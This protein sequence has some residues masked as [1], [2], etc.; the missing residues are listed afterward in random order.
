[1]RFCLLLLFLAVVTAEPIRVMFL[2]GVHGREYATVLVCQDIE[3]RLAATHQDRFAWKVIPEVNPDGISLARDQGKSCHRGNGRGVDLNRNWPPIRKNFDAESSWVPERKTWEVNPG[4]KPFSEAETRWIKKEI[5]QFK[6]HL[7]LEFHTGECA[8][9]SPYQSVFVP[10]NNHREHMKFSHWLLHEQ[11]GFK[12]NECKRGAGLTTLY[13]AVGTL[14]DYAYEVL[15]VP[16]VFIVETYSTPN[17][18]MRTKPT[19]DLDASECKAV[20]VPSDLDRYVQTWGKVADALLA[21]PDNEY[22]LL[23]QWTR[24]VQPPG[25]RSQRAS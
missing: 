3:R 1:M 17:I 12:R 16:M 5:E 15:E 11:L 23:K 2:C 4:D 22:Q 6:P 24:P 19:S 14:M 10:P 13:Q 9:L 21:L 20:F 18:T 25:S 8:M 7:L